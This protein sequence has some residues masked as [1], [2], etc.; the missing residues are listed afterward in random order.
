MSVF[1]N[2]DVV[3]LTRKIATMG[4]GSSTSV[5]RGAVNVGDEALVTYEFLEQACNQNLDTTIFMNLSPPQY[6]HTIVTCTNVSA[7]NIQFLIPS[8]T[9]CNMYVDKV[10][11][12]TGRNDAYQLI[13]QFFVLPKKIF[14]QSVVIWANHAKNTTNIK[15]FGTG[16]EVLGNRVVINFD[17]FTYTKIECTRKQFEESSDYF[18]NLTIQSNKIQPNIKLYPADNSIKTHTGYCIVSLETCSGIIWAT[19][20]DHLK[21]ISNSLTGWETIREQKERTQ[22]H[23]TKRTTHDAGLMTSITPVE[24]A[25]KQITT[26]L[27]IKGFV[28]PAHYPQDLVMIQSTGNCEEQD[29][30]SDFDYSYLE[31]MEYTHKPLGIIIAIDEGTRVVVQSP[32]NATA[33]SMPHEVEIPSKHAFLFLGDVQHAGAGYNK[34][35]IRLHSYYLNHHSPLAIDPEAIDTFYGQCEDP[36]V[37]I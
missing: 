18:T 17:I 7:T 36:R 21:K 1:I 5:N 16:L 4:A 26:Y 37:Y 15:C 28:L 29:L 23:I 33:N 3:L 30:H 9:K 11:K 13:D 2:R 14:K 31:G 22:F 10:L 24:V 32:C 6:Q 20:H 25:F 8:K 35:N 19:L 27:T 12:H 34:D